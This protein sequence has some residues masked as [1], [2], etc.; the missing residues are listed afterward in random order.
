MKFKE[1]VTFRSFLLDFGIKI[2]GSWDWK[3]HSQ[4]GLPDGLFSDQKIGIWVHFG[5]SCN[6]RCWR[7][8]WKFDIFYAPLLYF[9]VIWY[10][11]H[12]FGILYQ[13]KSGNPA[14]DRENLS[15]HFI[16]IWLPPYNPA[17]F[18]LTT[19]NILSPR[20]ETI[21]HLSIFLNICDNAQTYFFQIVE[22]WS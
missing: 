15:A 14:L 10:I 20:A 19:P 12:C 3:R 16:L 8:L 7:I 18:D 9:V 22:I 2:I 21:P 1:L 5:E 17:G 13:E 11:F 4:S 6:V